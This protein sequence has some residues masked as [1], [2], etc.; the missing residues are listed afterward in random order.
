M[1]AT[2]DIEGICPSGRI[3][4]KVSRHAEAYKVGA[5]WIVS[6]RRTMP[7]ASELEAVARWLAHNGTNHK[8]RVLVYR[9]A[10]GLAKLSGVVFAAGVRWRH[11]DSR[12]V[13]VDPTPER[14]GQGWLALDH[15]AR[16]EHLFAAMQAEDVLVRRGRPGAGRG[17][18]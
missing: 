6:G 5:A 8:Q 2:V 17:A 11:A 15:P 1:K 3:A 10:A 12:P 14:T 9:R 13:Y 16:V 18:R 7:A 4:T